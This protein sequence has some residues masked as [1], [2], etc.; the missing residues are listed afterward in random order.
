MAGKGDSGRPKFSPPLL[1]E[2]LPSLYEELLTLL[3][4]PE[5]EALLP[6]LPHLRVTGRCKC[7]DDFCA[8]IDTGH[9]PKE[10]RGT[11][12]QDSID[13]EADEGLMILDT[14][15]GQIVSIEIL[16]RDDIRE[17]VLQRIP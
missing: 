11:S 7:G 10:Y 2:V 14:L 8:T 5:L 16:Y 4:K 6:Q 17:L 9:V 12:H 1:C 15:D 3:A 13:I